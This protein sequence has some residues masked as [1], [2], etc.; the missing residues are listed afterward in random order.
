MSNSERKRV[1]VE[2]AW[3]DS[4]CLKCIKQDVCAKL[5]EE[6]FQFKCEYFLNINKIKDWIKDLET[7]YKRRY[8]K[9]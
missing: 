8:K 9:S 5:I 4:I 7:K 3:K 6:D 1:V 2:M